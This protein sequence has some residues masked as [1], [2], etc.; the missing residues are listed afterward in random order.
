M[1]QPI[2]RGPGDLAV[3]ATSGRLPSSQP[4]TGSAL[5]SPLDI[6]RPAPTDRE[7]ANDVRPGAPGWSLTPKA[8]TFDDCLLTCLVALSQLL[9]RPASPEVLKA[10]LPLEEGRLTPDLAIRAAARAGLSARL[11]RRALAQISDF[12]LPC[13][14]L[15]EG[16]GA[17]V[18]VELLEDAKARVLLPETGRGALELPLAELAER[19]TGYALFARPEV[20]F[21]RRAEQVESAHVGSW[22]WGTLMQAWPIYAEVML[23]AVLINSFALASP[24]FIMNVYDRVV[25]NNALETLWVLAAG[26][27]TV[28]LF[29]FLLRNLRGYFVDSAGKMADV[30]LASRIFE[31][32]LGI[33]MAARPASAG[34]SPTICASSRACATSSPRPPSSPS[35]TCRSCCSSS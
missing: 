20:R 35:S 11:V 12:T 9:E 24:L 30:K 23:A 27:V 18:L 31:H 29:D 22:F 4:A 15:L 14:L 8:S 2:R 19:Y 6:P 17:C 21:D 33:R 34:P 5:Q 10:G 26:V 13:I 28:F 25:P 32:V 1:A 16:R 7:P 3:P